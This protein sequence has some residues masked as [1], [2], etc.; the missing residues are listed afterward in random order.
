MQIAQKLY[1]AGHITYMRTDS[2]N[3]A[4]V[5]QEQ[6]VQLVQ[7]KYGKEYAEARIYKTKSKNAQE[8]HEA[9][10]P[11]HVE[12]MV[13]GTDEQDRLYRLIWERTVSSQMTDAKLLKTKITA[14]IEGHGPDDGE[15]SLPEF[16]AVGSRLLFPG[17]L[18]VDSDARGDDVE[19]PLC[20]EG[21]KL[22][23]L[24]LTNEEKFTE[25]PSRY[26]EAGL[27]KELE[28]RGIGRP[29]TYA[30]IMKTIEERGYVKKES[31]GERT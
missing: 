8:A 14:R 27:I 22:K 31:K 6:I 15:A 18:K 10:R 2:T 5:A 20:K 23:L 1:E 9:I 19:L 13:V 11:T 17:W 4:A 3:L 30:S 29:S 25:P 26:S 7:K 21:E 24:N 16:G 12:N 28:A